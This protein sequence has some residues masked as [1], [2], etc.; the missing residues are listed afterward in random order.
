V[1]DLTVETLAE[2]ATGKGSLYDEDT[3]LP[4][5]LFFGDV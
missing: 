1:A 3:R 4:E 2:A 5:N